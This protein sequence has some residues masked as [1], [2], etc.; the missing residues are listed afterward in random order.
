M[1]SGPSVSDGARA[2]TGLPSRL[3]Q[4]QDVSGVCRVVCFSPRHDLTLPQMPDSAIRRVVDVWAEQTEELGRRFPWVQVFENKGAIMGCS[5]PHPHGQ[6]WAS[7]LLP[8]IPAAEDGRQ[9]T[10][11][12]ETGQILLLD[13]L[14]CEHEQ[15]ERIVIESDHWMVLVPYWATWPFETLLVPK[16]HVA[17]LPDLQNDERNDLAVVLKKLLIRYDNLFDTSFPYSMGWHGAHRSL[18]ARLRIGSCMPTSS[19]RCSAR[20]P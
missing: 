19:H 18:Q 14:Q 16:R 6:I 12:Q 11:L 13:Y 5:N 9:A 10:Y 2:P 17:R 1:I 20:R 8:E 3:F 4:Q 15:Q 7:S